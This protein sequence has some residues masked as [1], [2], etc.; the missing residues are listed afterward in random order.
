M[1]LLEI[2]AVLISIVGVVLTV[3]RH[4]LCWVFNILAYIL[5]G[6]LFYEYK[7]YGETILQFIFVILSIYGF[8]H[9]MKGRTQDHVIKI[10]ESKMTMQILQLVFASISGLIFGLALQNFTEASL[11]ILDAQLAAFSLL[12]TYWTAQRYIETWILWIVVDIIYVGMFA[13]KELY[14]TAVLYAIFIGLAG[15]GLTEWRRIR[16]L[17]LENG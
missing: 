10:E 5:Y 12:A 16:K 17:Q 7:L 9:W 13:Y 6:Y 15:Y 14:L 2:V 1:S 8:I 11:P 4:P 3:K